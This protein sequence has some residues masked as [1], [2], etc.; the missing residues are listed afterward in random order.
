MQKLLLF[1]ITFLLPFISYGS[2]ASDA[3][4]SIYESL[5]KE[6]QDKNPEISIGITEDNLWLV[7]VDLNPEANWGHEVTY[8]FLP[9][10]GTDNTILRTEIHDFPPQI[11]LTKMFTHPAS[12]SSPM[13]SAEVPVRNVPVAQNQYAIIL[14]GGINDSMNY[15]R[16]WND[17]SYIYRVMTHFYNVPKDN[18][19]VAMGDGTSRAQNYDLDGDGKCEINYAASIEDLE[20][21]FQDLGTKVTDSDH[22][23]I[24]V[25]DHGGRN[26][27]M[28][29]SYIYLWNNE[30]LYP[31]TLNSWLNNLNIGSINC[32]FG[33]C[34][35]GGF[36]QPLSGPNR[37]IATAC[38]ENEY[39]YSTPDFKYDSFVHAW[40]TGLM[41]VSNYAGNEVIEAD[42]DGDSYVNMV[43]AFYFAYDNDL[44]GTMSY[45]N[46]ENPQFSYENESLAMD[47]CFDR[48]PESVD[49]YIRDNEEDL[50]IEPN[51]YPFTNN[52]PD[53]WVR[54]QNDG[55]VTHQN[56]IL[57]TAGNI[58][59][60]IYV[61]IRNKGIKD[62]IP[63]QK[64]LYLH[65]NWA[66]GCA[67][68]K[69]TT[70]TGIYHDS[71]SKQY[72]SAIKSILIDKT[73][74]S[75]GEETFCVEWKTKGLEMELEE[76]SPLTIL[77]TISPRPWGFASDITAN[78]WPTINYENQGVI[79]CEYKKI[80]IKN[81][82]TPEQYGKDTWECPIRIQ[83]LSHC[84]KFYTLKVQSGNEIPIFDKIDLT[85]TTRDGFFQ[86][87]TPEAS[88]E[89]MPSGSSPIHRVVYNPDTIFNFSSSFNQI[90][91]FGL[92]ENQIEKMILKAKVKDNKYVGNISTIISLLD[93]PT[94]N[95]IGS[96]TFLSSLNRGKFNGRTL[97]INVASCDNNIIYLCADDSF[98]SPDSIEYE[99][100]D[101]EGSLLGK[102][103]EI[104][105]SPIEARE[106]ILS[107]TEDDKTLSASINLASL[108]KIKSV[109]KNMQN[110][111]VNLNIS[112][113]DNT[114]LKATSINNPQIVEQITIPAGSICGNINISRFNDD[115]INLAIEHNGKVIDTI[116]IK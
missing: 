14:S 110:L 70:F 62:Y 116:S 99:W 75:G 37:I 55:N 34:F 104:R 78:I 96:Y 45:N 15:P 13:L 17:C 73:I 93:Y 61:K 56:P 111:Q 22:L 35:S 11:P 53:I 52:S 101:E 32:V 71:A 69:Y 64:K 68:Q 19:Y 39:S 3:V 51:V 115:I 25:I 65:L 91:Y 6:E 107:T 46:M 49:L 31:N 63:S 113:N 12:N 103:D 10:T 18:I 85:L 72:G 88:S 74:P 5:T 2:N 4:I 90:K 86:I 102:G 106:I 54:N 82:F 47:L 30:E 105:I 7:M 108:L 57:K 36:I 98:D 9:R 1:A 89:P 20:T 100:R 83:S 60:Y 87:D 79:A 95:I 29:T 81:L 28:N 43:E 23:F 84:K 38:D 8:Y 24:Y 42:I 16:Y 59:N 67:A 80:A 94:D 40:T 26:Y 41:N 112:S 27:A 21:I 109:S 44:Y 66:S 114:I 50:G 48:H 33:Q 58:E 76:N 77:A 92:N 97:R